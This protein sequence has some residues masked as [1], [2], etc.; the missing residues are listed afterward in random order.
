M[1]PTLNIINLHDNIVKL[2][3]DK[4]LIGYMVKT[5]S[6]GK[7]QAIVLPNGSTL[8]DFSCANEAISAVL[9]NFTGIDQ[10]KI[11][12]YPSAI[13]TNVMLLALMAFMSDVNH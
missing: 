13:K 12:L 7:S 9:E 3:L 10:S 2:K 4:T 1:T 11:V 8:G 5:E 6:Q